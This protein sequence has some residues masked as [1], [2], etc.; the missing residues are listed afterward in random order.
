MTQAGSPRSRSAAFRWLVLIIASLVCFA[1]YYVYDSVTSLES[2]I[3]AE[4]GFTRAQY[5]LLFSFYSV[6]NVLLFMVLIAGVLVDRLGLK[7]SGVLYGFLCFLGAAVTAV[8]AMPGLATHLGPIH[9]WLR[10][11]FMPDWSPEL[12]IMLLGRMIYG[13]G[14]EAILVVN[15]KIL[16]RWFSGKELAFAFGA[17][18]TLMRLGTVL[19]V[20]GQVPIADVWG[21]SGALW[22]TAALMG[23]GFASFFGYLLLERTSKP[24][25]AAAGDAAPTAPE[26][27]FVLRDA[28]TFSPAFWYVALLCVT[29][30]SAIFPFAA[31][32][33]DILT[34]RFGY[35]PELAARY[36]SILTAGTMIFT[37]L[38]GRLIDRRGHRATLMLLGS[39]ILFP[40]HLLI[41]YTHLHPAIP[42]F[43]AGVAFSI[44]PAALWAAIPL[45]VP[46]RHLGTAYGVVGYVQ[47]VGLW[48]F[49]WLAGK[50]A[51]AHTTTNAAGVQVVD[52]S[53]TMLMFAALGF[54]GFVFSALLKRA[55]ARRA[56]GLSLEQVVLHD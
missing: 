32:A 7:K 42:L 44:V 16:A 31:H 33:P 53:S 38:F 45:M 14:A 34:Q 37:P 36:A 19:A 1:Q 2:R 29:F 15:N 43:F 50:I 20:N 10:T 4:L 35:S 5:G 46:E 21:L 49:P 56:G 8:G 6:P 17:N 3:V 27:R 47:N 13:V 26:E 41:G 52:Y 28:F 24:T 30:Y 39:L 51:D 55:N 40:C 23:V 12:K 11:A 18:L 54:A 9:G 48:L 22:F 25:A